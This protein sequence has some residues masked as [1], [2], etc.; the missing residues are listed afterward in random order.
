MTEYQKIFEETAINFGYKHQI[1]N[2]YIIRE[3][4]GYININRQ[5]PSKYIYGFYEKHLIAD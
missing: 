4:D 5:F 2:C 1:D 3:Y